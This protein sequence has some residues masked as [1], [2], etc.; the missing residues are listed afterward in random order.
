SSSPDFTV[1]TIRNPLGMVETKMAQQ[2]QQRQKF[3]PPAQPQQAGKPLNDVFGRVAK[4]FKKVTWP[5]QPEPPPKDVSPPPENVQLLDSIQ[6]NEDAM[7]QNNDSYK[8]VPT[9]Y[10]EDPDNFNEDVWPPP[11]PPNLDERVVYD[12]S[13]PQRVI[14]D[15][16]V[17][18]PVEAHPVHKSYKIAPGTLHV[19]SQRGVLSYDTPDL[20]GAK[21][22][23]ETK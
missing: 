20:G 4:S 10:A 2:G 22:A 23:P 21:M 7:F 16:E 6:L 17:Q 18:V 15:F 1:A 13:R 11:V 14:R 8:L 12:A 19:F 9:V 3:D 5:P